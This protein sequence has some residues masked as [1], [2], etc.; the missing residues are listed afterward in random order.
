MLGGYDSDHVGSDDMEAILEFSRVQNHREMGV[1]G[2][3]EEAA[4]P[5]YLRKHELSARLSALEYEIQGVD[6]QVQK[7]K[8]LRQNLLAEKQDVLRQ[9]QAISHAQP[10]ITA[11]I[12]GKGKAKASGTIDYAMEFDW[13]PQLKGTM[14]KVFGISSFRLCQQGV[15]NANM[16]GRDV[17]CVMPTGGG[18]SLTYQLPALLTPGCTLVISPLISLIT[19]QI[20]HLREAGVE[21][22][23]LTGGTSKA[24]ANEIQ[25]RLIE[26]ASSRGG[27]QQGDIKLCYVTPEKIAKSKAF[28]FLLRK[29]VEGGKLARIVIDEAHCVS[30]LGHDF[31]PDYKKLSALR[32]FFPHV[33]ILALSATCPPKVL[34]DILKI[35]HMK[36][37]VDGKAAPREGT[38]Y[39]SAPLYR[40]NLHYSVVPKPSSA[41]EVVSAMSQ[42]ILQNHEHDSGI[43]YCLT[44]KDAETVA[45]S[46]Q[47]VS[48]GRIKTGV[49]HADVADGQKEGLH[50][51]WRDGSIQVVCATIAFGLGID[52]GNVRFV[53]HHTK[54]LDGYYQESGRAGR[55][56]QDADC[57]LY[58]RPQ[59]AT[60]QSSI[61]CTDTD[62]TAKLH[63]M[64]RFAQDIQECRKILFAKYFSA[65][66]DLSMTSWTTEESSAMDKCGHCD[67]CTRAPETVEHKDVTTEAWQILKILEAVDVQG[68]RQTIA[69][70]SDLARGLGGG[71]FEAGGKRKKAKAKVQL[72]YD[73]VAGGKVGLSK[74]DIETLIVQLL[75]SRYLGEAFSSTAYTVNVYVIPGEL[76]LR[77]TRLARAD[78]VHGKGPRIHCSFKRQARKGK[79]ST[80]GAGTKRKTGARSDGDGGDVSVTTVAGSSRPRKRFSLDGPAYSESEEEDRHVGS[81]AKKKKKRL[82][83]EVDEEDDED[84][85]HAIRMI[86]EAE[87]FDVESDVEDGG[88]EYSLRPPVQGALRAP[89]KKVNETFYIDDDVI[90]LSSD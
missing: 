3:S 46:L 72:D 52:K 11:A 5:S 58:Y 54:S 62:G 48:N 84:F 53:L 42:Y 28:M 4:Q 59:D 33:P 82:Q 39:F 38:I 32:Q 76:A 19:D 12:N 66:S 13:A 75:V 30:Q 14:K 7:L 65:S 18:K 22:A 68:G 41:K 57:L 56:G 2:S 77:L 24:L 17:V 55:D 86:D 45:A 49:Y 87:P 90:S 83:A 27:G 51:Q 35:L 25:Q 9:T 70:L 80:A 60:R 26:M 81:L 88:W 85:T 47:D 21:A 36:P 69:G 73:A 74:D 64:L 71:S 1:A 44:K 20:L 50:R 29:L 23:K 15:C 67:N 16:D 79:A 10:A 43:V 8:A 63:D 40:K 6:E 61:T 89:S 31:R 78:V 34:Q 37:V